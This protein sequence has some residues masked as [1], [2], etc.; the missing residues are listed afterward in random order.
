MKI[1]ALLSPDCARSGVPGVSKKRIFELIS[2]LASQHLPDVSPRQLFDSLLARERLGST[3]IGRGIAIPHGR[4]PCDNL[5][6]GKRC[7][8]VLIQCEKPIDF[9]AIDRQ[10]VDLLFAL[11]VPHD[12]CDQHLDTLAAVAEQLN[13]RHICKQLRQ[14]HSDLELYEIMTGSTA[15][16][17]RAERD[18]PGVEPALSSSAS[19][20]SSSS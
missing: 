9:D 12:Q 11:F 15:G 18:V 10:P 17:E 8:A 16:A 3:G 5:P 2:E 7:V 1:S 14:A 13:D 6:D 19:S 20:A 4:L